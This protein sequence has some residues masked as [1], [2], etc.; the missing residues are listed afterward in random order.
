MA[1][2]EGHEA[3]AQQLQQLQPSGSTE[4]I[5]HEAVAAQAGGG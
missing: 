1:R 5:G 3:V 2:L 4:I